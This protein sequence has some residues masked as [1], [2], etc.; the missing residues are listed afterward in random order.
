[1]IMKKGTLAAITAVILLFSGCNG[2][3]TIGTGDVVYFALSGPLA[4]LEDMGF[5]KGM[6]LA[7][8][9][10]NE[11]TLLD[12]KTIV[13]EQFDDREDMTEGIKIAQKVAAA[14]QYS[15]LIG[16][17]SSNIALSTKNTYNDK[18]I[19]VMSPVISNVE[20]TSP[21]L[22][23]IFRNVASD[24]TEVERILQYA[25]DKGYQNLAICY[26]GN[27][28]GSQLS[29]IMSSQAN[30]FGITIIDSHSDFMNQ[31]EYQHQFEK[32]MAMDVDA[33]YI[34]D[35]MP[36][37]EGLIQLIRNSDP[38]I[39]ILGT[40][41][42]AL[43]DLIETLGAAANQISYVDPFYTDMSN[44]AIEAFYQAYEQAYGE[45]PGPLSLSGYDTILL[46][47]DAIQ[48][49]G[50][51]YPADLAATLKTQGPWKSTAQE[52]QFDEAGNAL[53]ISLPIIEIVNGT[54]Q[55]VK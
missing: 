38:D 26:R 35:S 51:V 1:M 55:I 23:T 31:A 22:D 44:P 48:G 52:I 42:F 50:S 13:V 16:P 15:A 49:A 32:W 40:G 34:G 7:I 27:D 17:F 41:G 21:P 9:E 45:D 28:Y 47:A 6:E 19:L 30:E 5:Q 2:G 18:K 8:A 3:T 25:A 14:N 54:Y 46:L 33:I 39:P 37:V 4:T 36:E 29:Q 24:A 10:V 12:G 20:F 43:G 11:K 53:G